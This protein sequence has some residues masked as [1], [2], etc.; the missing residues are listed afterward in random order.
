MKLGWPAAKAYLERTLHH[1]VAIG[2]EWIGYDMPVIIAIQAT[3][4]LGRQQQPQQ[5]QQQQRGA[6]GP[7]EPR[8]R[9]GTCRDFNNNGCT[10]GAALCKWKHSCERCGTAG[11]GSSAC[12]QGPP[13]KARNRATAPSSSAAQARRVF[14]APPVRWQLLRCP[15]RRTHRRRPGR[16]SDGAGTGAPPQQQCRRLR[17]RALVR[18]PSLRTSFT[19]RRRIESP[20]LSSPRWMQKRGRES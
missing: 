2:Q 5:Q 14:A 13:R 9:S 17:R 19:C 12:S 20:S 8:A 6:V 10:R 3:A 4:Q 1:H 15:S 16:P 7:S 18:A 11:H